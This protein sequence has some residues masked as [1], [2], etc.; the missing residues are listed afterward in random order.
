V[1]ER[2]YMALLARALRT[3]QVRTKSLSNE[4]HFT[5]EA[6]TVSRSY[7]PSHCSGGTEI[8]H[9]ALPAHALRAV[10]VKL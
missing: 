3:V 8:C 7:I 4:G 5:L 6:E 2:C 10:K 9:M 1:T